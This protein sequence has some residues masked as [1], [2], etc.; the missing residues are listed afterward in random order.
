MPGT[1]ATEAVYAEMVVLARRLRRES[2]LAHPALTMTDFSILSYL[3]RSVEATVTDT[4][5]VFGLNKSTASRQ[6]AGLIERGWILR[7]GNPDDGRVSH[8]QP[9]AAGRQVLEQAR[10]ELR[11]AFVARLD[12][13]PAADV[14]R[15]AELLRRY[16]GGAAR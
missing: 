5:Q 2:G 15:F 1:E 6:I 3:D 7:Q 13:W 9:S 8:L 11:A 14:D 10:Q 12:G 4:A 16:N